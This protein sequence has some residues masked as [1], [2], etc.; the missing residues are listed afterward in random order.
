MYK[1][2][3]TSVTMLISLKA[4]L[5]DGYEQMEVDDKWKV[6][7]VRAAEDKQRNMEH[8][9]PYLWYECFDSNMY[10]RALDGWIKAALS[11]I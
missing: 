3:L 4:A 2:Y 1:P 9:F 5:S 6:G 7:H 10:K 11:L 8:C